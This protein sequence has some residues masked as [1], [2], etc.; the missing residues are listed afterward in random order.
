[1]TPER[2]NRDEARTAE[3]PIIAYHE[4]GH[5]VLAWTFGLEIERISTVSTDTSRGKT[6]ICSWEGVT[7]YHW[8]DAEG[9]LLRAHGLTLLAGEVAVEIL[10]GVPIDWD[11]HADYEGSDIDLYKD[12]CDEYGW[13]DRTEGRMDFWDLLPRHATEVRRHLEERWPAVEAVANALLDPVEITGEEAVRMMVE[14]GC[15]GPVACV[16]ADF[17]E[18]L[19]REEELAKG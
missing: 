19:R 6:T 16:W 17:Q 14:T 4:A 8:F 11:E 3:P 7:G 5:A 15:P 10:S 12:H 18:E 1:M 9:A 13:P 2:T